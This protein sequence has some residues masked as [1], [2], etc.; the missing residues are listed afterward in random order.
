MMQLP[1][2]LLQGAM[3]N[4]QEQSAKL[5]FHIM[6]YHPVLSNMHPNSI[7]E[8]KKHFFDGGYQQLL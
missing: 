6:V 5:E 1:L 3:K 2:N 7:T 8:K 4:I